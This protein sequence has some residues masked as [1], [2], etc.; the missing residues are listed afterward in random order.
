MAYQIRPPAAHVVDRED[1]LRRALAAVAEWRGKAR[2]L[3]IAVSGLSGVG[4]T[5]LAFMIARLF[6]DTLG[7][8]LRDL[9]AAHP[10]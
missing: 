7:Q 1:E 3:T 10:H 4:K 9:G 2:L 6:K 5:E 8:V